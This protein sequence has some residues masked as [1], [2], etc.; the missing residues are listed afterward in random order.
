MIKLRVFNRNERTVTHSTRYQLQ[1][2]TVTT[3][4]QSAEWLGPKINTNGL[5]GKSYH[6]QR[7]FFDGN[8]GATLLRTCINSNKLMPI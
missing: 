1:I 3:P 2:V 7:S 6:G 4:Y 8:I 5:E